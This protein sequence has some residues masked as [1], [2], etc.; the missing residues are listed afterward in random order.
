MFS[1]TSEFCFNAFSGGLY[2]YTAF[3]VVRCVVCIVSAVVNAVVLR[4][5]LRISFS[6]NAKCLISHDLITNFVNLTYLGVH[7]AFN[8]HNYVRCATGNPL[9]HA[10]LPCMMFYSLAFQIPIAGKCRPR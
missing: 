5:F 10:L 3:E 7:D 1:N 8:M 4:A 9:T 6:R 2:A